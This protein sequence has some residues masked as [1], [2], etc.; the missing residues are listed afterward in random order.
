MRKGFT[1]MLEEILA[2][3]YELDLGWAVILQHDYANNETRISKVERFDPEKHHK[4]I[5]AQQDWRRKRIIYIRE[6]RDEIDAY[7]QAKKQLEQAE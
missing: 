2:E 3:A 5:A 1:I 6:G 4:V 7:M